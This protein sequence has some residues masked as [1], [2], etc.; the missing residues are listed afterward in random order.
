MKGGESA[1]FSKFGFYYKFWFSKGRFILLMRS[2]YTI[3]ATFL[4]KRGRGILLLPF[5][6]D[7]PMDN[8]KIYR[9]YNFC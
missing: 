3:L 5:P 7:L 1:D 2:F 6:L 8:Y 9:I 4:T